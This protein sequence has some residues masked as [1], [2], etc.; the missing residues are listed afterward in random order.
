MVAAGR[1]WEFNLGHLSQRRASQLSFRGRGDKKKKKKRKLRLNVPLEPHVW[2][3]LD[4][5]TAAA[6]ALR[7][8]YP[9]PVLLVAQ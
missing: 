7:F 4:Q 1:E 5:I 8:F 2:Q 9:P 6:A 3:K